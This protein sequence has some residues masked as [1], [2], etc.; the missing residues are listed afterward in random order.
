MRT[1]FDEYIDEYIGRAPVSRIDLDELV[2][3]AHGVRRRRRATRVGIVAVAVVAAVAAG[4]LAAAGFN[5]AARVPAGTPVSVT[6]A[7]TPSPT[8]PPDVATAARLLAA[9]QAAVRAQAPDVGGLD[10]LTRQYLSCSDGGEG[11]SATVR[12][13]APAT[14]M[15][16]NQTDFNTDRYQ[17]S[18]QLTSPAGTFSIRFYVSRSVY[19]DPSAPPI[20]AE[21]AAER[22]AAVANGDAPV[23]GP[24]GESILV[25]RGLLNLTKPDATNVVISCFDSAGV[26]GCP[27]TRDQLI[28]VGLSPGLHL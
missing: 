12:P 8:T 11:V 19:Y 22:A 1:E 10:T 14:C 17:W 24:D 23:R 28:A 13:T 6:P 16:A 2:R 3:Q 27:L 7:A 20:N 21:D 15:H 4:G 5:G 18:G 26:V 25:A 9:F